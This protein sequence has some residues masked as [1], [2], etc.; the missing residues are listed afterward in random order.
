MATI[1]PS[2]RQWIVL[3]VSFFFVLTLAQAPARLV[4]HFSNEEQIFFDGLQGT[5]WD[6]K[7][8]LATV[9]IAGQWISLGELEWQINPVQLLLGQLVTSMQSRHPL[10]ESDV[11]LKVRRGQLD[12]S[13][14][15]ITMD[16]RILKP[17]LPKTIYARGDMNV[18]TN[19]LRWS[20]GLQ[21]IDAEVFWDQAQ[22]RV[23]GKKYQLGKLILNAQS[24]EQE[25][26][27]ALDS[28]PDSSSQWTG[29]LSYYDNRIKVDVRV[30]PS[31][32][33]GKNLASFLRQ[34]GG[35]TDE[36]GFHNLAFE[37]EL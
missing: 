22:L 21:R 11:K 10:L 15:R 20:N 36:Q 35:A 25:I 24:A 18:R 33:T 23:L 9:R 6:G 7:A 26:R 34:N 17:W 13:E 12:I 31:P 27:L 32:N 3:A 1:R 2:K 5:V 19:D 29:E 37:Y 8:I 4:A 16:A 30:K 14:G 28:V